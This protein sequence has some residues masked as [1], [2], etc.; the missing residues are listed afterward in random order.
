M[1]LFND[2]YQYI[3]KTRVYRMKAKII[4]TIMIIII[5][6]VIKCDVI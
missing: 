4:N 5:I 2:M 6:I 1:S 3:I